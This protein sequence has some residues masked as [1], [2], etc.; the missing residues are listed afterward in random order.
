M[1]PVRFS[2]AR[3]DSVAGAVECLAAAGPGAR[4]LAGGQSLLALLNQRRVRP[5]TVVDVSRL[6]ELRYLRL[7]GPALR[8]GALATHRAVETVRDPAV[9]AGFGVLPEAARLVGHLPVRTRGTFGGSLAHADPAAEWCLV[10]V[11]LDA[12][13]EVAGPGGTRQ[14]AAADFFTGGRRGTGEHRTALRWDEVLVEVRLPQPAPTAALVEFA[15]QDGQLPL[16]AAA[17]AVELDRSGAVAAARLA[18]G[19]VADRPLR[20]PWVERAVLGCL[21]DEDLLDRAG[22]LAAGR[23]DPPG[24]VRADGWYRREL[25]AVLTGRA[26]RASIARATAGQAARDQEG[27]GLR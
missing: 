14:V 20:L 25:A 24:D 10:A 26:L 1:K 27:A 21:A 16:V 11:L 2:Y 19:G 18:L 17:A 6:D 5:T 23:L 12:E 9:L 7:D 13:L 3:P 22:R 8:I 4:L 15:A